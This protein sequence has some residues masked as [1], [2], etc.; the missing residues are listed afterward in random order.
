[1]FQLGSGALSCVPGRAAP[2]AARVLPLLRKPFCTDFDFEP[3]M[4]VYLSYATFVST[5][6]KLTAGITSHYLVWMTI[7]G[8]NVALAIGSIAFMMGHGHPREPFGGLGTSTHK[9][10]PAW[11]PERAHVYPF[12]QYVKDVM[13]WSIA[14]DMDIMRQG[15]AVAMQ[16]TGAAKL[17]ISQILEMDNG[18]LMLQRGNGE[19][20][21]LM[22]LLQNIGEKFA[23]LEVE[24]STRAMNDMMTFKRH[25]NESI[26]A[27][28]TR[29][30]MVR[31]RAMTRGGMGMTYEGL[32]WILMRSVGLNAD[33]W[34]RCL[35]QLQGRMPTNDYEFNLVCD[36]LRRYGHLHEHNSFMRGGAPT[37]YFSNGGNDQPPAQGGES[38]YFPLFEG[39]GAQQQQQAPQPST[40]LPAHAFMS[41]SQFLANGAV[42]SG[43]AFPASG[44]E[45]QVI[46]YPE[47]QCHTCG[48]FLDEEFS[49]ATETDNENEVLPQASA[50][51]TLAVGAGDANN[52]NDVQCAIYQDYLAH[53]RLW[54]RVSQRPPRRYRKFNKVRK[55]H[56]SKFR[57]HGRYAAFLPQNAFAGHRGP[58][59][60]KTKFSAHKRKTNPRGKDGK[61]LECHKCGST[62]HLQRDCPQNQGTATGL[63]HF[64]GTANSGGAAGVSPVLDLY[65]Q[66]PLQQMQAMSF[67]ATGGIPNG[68]QQPS[69]EAMH[70]ALGKPASSSSSQAAHFALPGV[71]FTAFAN[72]AATPSRAASEV[73]SVMSSVS[74]PGLSQ[75]IQPSQWNDWMQAQKGLKT[76]SA[77]TGTPTSQQPSAPTS[78]IAALTEQ[79]ASP[80]AAVEDQPA[81]QDQEEVAVGTIVPNQPFSNDFPDPWAGAKPKAP[82]FA[83]GVTVHSNNSWNDYRQGAGSEAM[84]LEKGGRKLNTEERRS[85]RA[86]EADV[87]G[88]QAC[89]FINF[90]S[91]RP[92][93]PPPGFTPFMP[94]MPL[95]PAPLQPP[96]HLPQLQQAPPQQQF[97]ALTAGG[98]APAAD[99]YRCP[100]QNQGEEESK[101]FPWWETTTRKAHS[102]AYHL[103]TRINGVV[104]LLVDPGAHDNLIGER[105]MKAMSEQSGKPIEYQKLLAPM[106][107]EGVGK[108]GQTADQSGCVPIGV[109]GSAGTF[110]APIIPDSDLPPLLGMRTL[111]GRKAILDCGNRRLIFPG[112]GGVHMHLSPGSLVFELEKSPSGHLILP[113]TN[114][115]KEGTAQAED[116]RLA[117]VSARPLAPAN[118]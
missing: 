113:T 47:E 55:R 41:N 44:P 29:F 65:T 83:S 31:T 116:E 30:E 8:L 13:L 23:P 75:L 97:A 99:D 88:R 46:L 95:M 26:D 35:D 90:G 18:L 21:G 76:Q 64:A 74:R 38:Y 107:V 66:Q 9:T 17:R 63:T 33:Q 81:V 86:A 51:Q 20:T 104:G 37:D 105:T 100:F 24:L 25:N 27:L 69:C 72:H 102:M 53:K 11:G 61:P 56:F 3:N 73:G 84:S 80:A 6:T 1:M 12:S 114:F 62:D 108:G 19:M 117:F 103:K 36:R 15:P 54:R 78:I 77:P 70:E 39:S 106:A 111:E 7:F 5:L 101:N 4:F 45:E 109:A 59:G 34:D 68:H 110:T 22:L 14:T 91:Q 58:G 67:M 118:N 16:M 87:L 57:T 60:P 50:Y 71:G 96:M 92:P 28:L 40:A 98:A 42:G 82:S 48:G 115:P 94:Q 43:C 2:F 93:P 85:V 112:P 32:T 10:P 79:A 89:G 49:S 52:D